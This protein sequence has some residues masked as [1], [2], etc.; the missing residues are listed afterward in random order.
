MN[1]TTQAISPE[2]ASKIASL[3]VLFRREF[4][5]STV[6][7]CPWVDDEETQS[8]LDPYS[9][10]LSFYLPKQIGNLSCR[11]ILIEVHFSEDLLL[12]YCQLQTIEAYGYTC[13]QQEW[14]FS[15]DDWR[16]VGSSIPNIESQVRFSKLV[17]C[18]S[19]LFAHPNQV[20]LLD[21]DAL[22]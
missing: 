18:I 2:L 4:S 14:Q 12:P 8:A 5:G 15:T 17:S 9:I 6:D 3:A 13:T 11:C 20:K 19:E 22:G 21:R 1:A 7:L 16:F 10:D